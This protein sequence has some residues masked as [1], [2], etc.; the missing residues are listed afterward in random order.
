MSYFKEIVEVIPHKQGLPHIV[1]K[2]GEFPHPNRQM[3]NVLESE[4]VNVQKFLVDI[5]KSKKKASYVLPWKTLPLFKR[6]LIHQT[7]KSRWMS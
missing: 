3:M 7:I 2:G 5:F 4:G 1:K 6:Q